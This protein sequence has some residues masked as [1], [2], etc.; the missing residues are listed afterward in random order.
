MQ[1]FFVT[2]AQVS[3]DVITVTG[4][5]VNHMK[6]VLRLKPGETVSISDGN[7]ARYLCQ[8][9]RYEP[10]GQK[11]RG[12]QSAGEACVL[13]IVEKQTVDSELPSKIYLFQALPKAGKMDT[14]VQK[15]VELGVYKVLPVM[16]RRCVTKPEEKQIKKKRSRWQEIAKSA[17]EQAGRGYIPEVTE[18]LSFSEAVER[19][20][21]LDVFLL[22]Y[23]LASDMAAD[24]SGAMT[25]TKEIL[26]AIG[27][28]Q[29]VGILIGPEGGFE[30]EEVEQAQDAGA[31]V[32]SLGKRILRTE[33][34]GPALLSILMFALE[35]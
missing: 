20:G 34:A 9:L 25:D 24:P 15:A 1:H 16:T 22:P 33:T 13:Q 31:R 7:N 32:I 26:A 8:I 12:K 23:E 17:A 4:S 21:G 35:A 3:D 10:S 27:P 30:K 18:L 19:A 14:I 11:E 29:S 2:P 6:N 5:D 28:G